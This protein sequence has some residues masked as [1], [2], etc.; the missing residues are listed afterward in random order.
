MAIET[1][2][3]YKEKKSES[4]DLMIQNSHITEVTYS[5]HLKKWGLLA[6]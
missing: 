4:D 6:R 2:E 1:L 3:T 5:H